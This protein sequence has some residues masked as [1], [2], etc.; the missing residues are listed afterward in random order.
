MLDNFIITFFVILF[1]QVMFFIYAALKKT[2]KV[3]D[4]SY[5]LTFILSAVISLA[6]NS[7]HVDIVK[8]VLVSIVSLWGVRL[9]TYLFIRIL[10]TKTDKRFDGIR[11]NPISFGFFWLVQAISVFIILL[12]TTY[13]LFISKTLDLNYISTIGAIVAI[14]GILIEGI[15][16]QQKFDFKNNEKNEGKWIQTG[17]WKYSR[18]PNYLGEILMW[19]GVSIFCIAYLNTEYPILNLIVYLIS[20]AYILFLLTSFSGI[21]TLEKKY[22][23]RY[24]ED[25][26]YQEY[27]KNTGVLIPKIF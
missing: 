19:I 3:T 4:L 13:T 20:P 7:Y 5:G 8:I 22:D 14:I 9:A 12:P 17:L 11:E 18:H 25:K 2:D 26:E 15:A 23:L 21:P 16:D 6:I 10:K 1:I 27:K 24:K